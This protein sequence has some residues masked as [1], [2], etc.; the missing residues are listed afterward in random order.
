M[1]L[2][3]LNFLFTESVFRSLSNFKNIFYYDV[4]SQQSLQLYWHN[5]V[6]IEGNEQRTQRARVAL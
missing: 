5:S 3:I 2:T 4:R 6:H 1:I